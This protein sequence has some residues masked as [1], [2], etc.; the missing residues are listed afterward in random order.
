MSQYNKITKESADKLSNAFRNMDSK[1]FDRFSDP[2]PTPESKKDFPKNVFKNDVIN[3]LGLNDELSDDIINSLKEKV[4]LEMEEYDYY[5]REVNLEADKK[6]I[7]R[8]KFVVMSYIGPN[9]HGKTEKFGFRIVDVFE[10]VKDSINFI[11][12]FEKN[13][14]DTGVVEMYKWIP[15]YPSMNSNETP[16]DISLFLNN[17]IISY[18]EDFI[19]NRLKFE[20]RKD[21]L[22]ENKNRFLEKEISDE[23]Y[24]KINSQFKQDIVND[25]EINKS[26]NV[27]NYSSGISNDTLTNEDLPSNFKSKYSYAIITIVRLKEHTDNS[28]TAIK[29]RGLF[30]NYDDCNSYCKMLM[31][32]DDTYDTLIVPT[33]QWVPCNPNSEDIDNKIY[34]EELNNIFNTMKDEETRINNVSFYKKSNNLSDIDNN[35]IMDFEEEETKSVSAFEKYLQL[36]GFTKEDLYN[37]ILKCIKTNVINDIHNGT[38]R[39]P[40][41]YHT[42]YYGTFDSNNIEE[43]HEMTRSVVNSIIR[44]IPTVV[45]H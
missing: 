8:Q 16:E 33:C 28:R 45:K 29:I 20:K 14:Y 2:Y 43:I 22:K 10:T 12:T 24:N 32:M 23:E 15:N 19:F 1:V 26:R 27:K 4:I 40:E 21:L 13:K 7:D 41:Y 42:Y 6:E 5:S 25:S 39:S 37:D 30:E 17:V 36:T 11:R 44:E 18:K 35:D 38:L 34:N 31:D 3:T 9:F